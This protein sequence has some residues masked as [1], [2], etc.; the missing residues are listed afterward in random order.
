MRQ[1]GNP[2]LFCHGL[3]VDPTGRITG[4]RL[5]QPDAKRKAVQALHSLNFQVIA[6]GDSYN[7]TAMLSEADTGIFFRPP[8]NVIREFPQFPV[9]EEYA[10][11]AAAIEES[12]AAWVSE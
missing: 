8:E 1:L 3:E 12:L 6:A 11:L 7:D 9:T 10:E 4:Y 2:T 5:R